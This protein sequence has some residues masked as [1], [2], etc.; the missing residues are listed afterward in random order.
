MT[1]A[2]FR[3][4]AAVG[5]LGIGVIV[6]CEQAPDSSSPNEPAGATTSPDVKEPSEEVLVQRTDCGVDFRHRRFSNP[7]KKYLPETAGSGVALLDYDGDGDLDLY[8]VQGAPLPG[9]K[10]TDLSVN[11]LYRNDGDFQFVDRTDPAGVGDAGYGMG[12]T[13]PDLDGDGYPELYVTNLR[14]N[15]LYHNRGDG[16]FEDVTQASGL[17]V[18]EWSTAAGWADY[19][20]DGDL[21]LYLANYAICDLENYQV[22]RQRKLLSYCHPDTFKAAPDQLFRNEG[23]LRFVDVTKAAGIVDTVGKGLAVLPFDHD[24]DGWLDWF[25]AN[26]SNENF[27]WRNRGDGTFEDIAPFTGTAV[28][29]K[30]ASQAC[31]GTDIGDVD[32]DLDFDIFAANFGK[33]ANVLYRRVE[34]DFYEDHIYSTGLGEASYFMTGFGSEF[35]DYDLDADLD[36]MVVNGH[37]IDVVEQLDPSQTFEQPAHFFENRGD[38]V[39]QE[40]GP[41]LG[42]YFR[43]PHLGRGLAVGDLDNDGD[44]DVVVNNNNQKPGLLENT[45]AS[46]HHWIGLRLIGR[47]SGRDAIGA[48]VTL[49]CADKTQVEAVRGSS[50]YLSWND[51]RLHFGV[52]SRQQPCDAKIR[53]PGGQVQE[54]NAL[55][56]DQYHEIQEP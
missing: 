27:L 21:D 37:I 20:K 12:A 35:F 53:W 50:S 15:K 47:S 32:G 49:T 14:G 33:E 25:I 56:L 40:I 46:N 45:Q 3:A 13:C 8:F 39:F 44:L 41:Q 6:S 26:D 54:L 55:A 17:G 9:S 2:G 5:L 30:G 52:G 34:E 38:G 36:L 19:D 48:H 4:L 16:T 51:L 43:E 23:G 10:N 29:G 24:D 22:C 1:V 31:M 11:R 28:S 42:A 7:N 18:T